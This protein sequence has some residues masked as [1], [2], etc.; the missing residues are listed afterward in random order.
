[1]KRLLI[2]SSML[3]FTCIAN[4]QTTDANQY[5][6]AKGR[7]DNMRSTVNKQSDEFVN[8]EISLRDGDIIFS[9]LPEMRGQIKA[10]VTNSSGE[11]IKQAKISQ[12]DNIMDVR[13]LHEGTLYFITIMYKNKTKKA[14][15]LNR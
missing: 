10:I 8:T 5:A 1:M 2:I 7:S 11:F 4:A 6:S 15:T 14:F 3:A 13:R 9:G 12:Q